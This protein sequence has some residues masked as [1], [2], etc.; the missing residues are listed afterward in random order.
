VDLEP[1]E[2]LNKRMKRVVQFPLGGKLLYT[3]LASF[4]LIA[5]LAV[6][7]N[8]LVTSRLISQYLLNAQTDRLNRDLDLANGF[9]QQKLN[10]VLSVSQFV[11]LDT[12]TR[13]YLPAALNGVTES[14]QTVD[15]VVSRMIS[16]RV[17]NGT[18][19]VVVLDPQGQV[20]DA[21]SV[22]AE[23]VLSP[24]F[25]GGDWS[26]LPVVAQALATGEPVSATE[27]IP[28]AYLA[29]VDLETQTHIV[30]QDTP[31]ANP[32]PFDP[33]EGSAALA[34]VGT[35][36]LPR[37]DGQS[38]GVVLT[39]YIFNNDFT[40]VD[41]IKN[42]A[43]VETMTL[44]LGDLRV[45][46]NVMGEDESRA[47]GTRA[48]QD[49]YQKV[50]VQ[51][52]DYAGRVFVVNNW[53]IG[54]YEPLRDFRDKVVGMMYVGVRETI[55]DSLM[56]AFN[57]RAAWIAFICILVAALIAIP[58]AR[59]ITRPI[60]LLVEANRRLAKGDM[61]VRVETKGKGEIALLG[62]SFNTMVETLRESEKELLHQAKL[63]SVGQLAAGVAHELNNP[64]GTILLY[65]DMMYKETPEGDPRKEDL[66]MILNEVQRCKT[67]V[68]DLLNFARQ[69]EIQVQEVAL[70]AL[71]DE[72][73]RKVKTRP[74]N[75]KV[76]FDCQCDPALP[77]IQ[78]DSAQLTQ[79]FLN[80]FNNSSYAMENCGRI[81]VAARPCD[82]NS[83]E[84]MVTDTG[85]G[86]PPENL[87]KLFTPFFTTK[88]A[89]KGTGLGLSIVYGIIKLHR[90]QITVRSQVGQGTIFTITLP[91]RQP[92]GAGPQ[93]SAGKDIIG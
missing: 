6:S 15:A 75:E 62:R 40:F 27:I 71:L 93:G 43:R 54:S 9:Y 22:T 85:A 32:I 76:E 90:G 91:V 58:I 16:G 52:G 24:A 47:V 10:D 34:I 3:L 5:V 11:A 82:G 14:I 67:I 56:V 64:L 70:P 84:L 55:F 31:K 37:I 38:S 80:L 88:P 12:Q 87:S 44:F 74:R 1:Q 60:A 57:T 48:A 29:D 46:T 83:V 42:E 21:R 65:S 73:I 30:A 59:L 92:D 61:S 51:G 45:S 79:V 7:L 20:L 66:K 26:A 17:L 13:V 78:A 53:Y 36:P 23:G 2:G 69:H 77:V 18:R 41:Y 25:T 89:G 19:M 33:R 39:A 63:A 50:L 35:Y 49:V 28:A 8:A 4:V 86:I 72:V 81:T 68:G